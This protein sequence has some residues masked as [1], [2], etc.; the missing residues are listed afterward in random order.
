MSSRKPVSLAMRRAAALSCRVRLLEGG[1][2]AAEGCIVAVV[3][4]EEAEGPTDVLSRNDASGGWDGGAITTALLVVQ[5]AESTGVRL[6]V[7]KTVSVLLLSSWW[8][9]NPLF[10]CKES[11]AC[12]LPVEAARTRDTL[13][14]GQE[15]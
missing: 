4:E 13:T 8:Y 6:S 5:D 7:L 2:A 9:K 1:A 14:A 15:N 12:L 3:T 10:L 11:A